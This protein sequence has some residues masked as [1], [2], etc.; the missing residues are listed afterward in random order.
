MLQSSRRCLFICLL[1]GRLLIPCRVFIL[2]VFH[3]TSTEE[4]NEM[5]MWIRTFTNFHPAEKERE[6][7]R[8]L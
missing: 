3:A 4:L 7:S 5:L 6:R 8:E 2:N 1:D